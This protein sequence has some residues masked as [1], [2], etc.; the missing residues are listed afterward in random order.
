MKQENNQVAQKLKIGLERVQELQNEISKTIS[1]LGEQLGVSISSTEKK[2]SSK[3]SS[4]R[5]KVPLK[6]FLFGGKLKKPKQSLFHCMTPL[7][8][9]LSLEKAPIGS[10]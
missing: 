1:T 9:L 6:S 10:V 8:I 2:K 3:S 4:I 5:S 7:F